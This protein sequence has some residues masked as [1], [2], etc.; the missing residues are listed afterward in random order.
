MKNPGFETQESLGGMV[1]LS[2][3]VSPYGLKEKLRMVAWWT[4]NALLFRGS[5]H[6]AN[7]FRSTLLR[8]FGAKIGR[9]V[10]IGPT[11]RITHPWR[12]EIGDHSQVG[13]HVWLYSLDKIV[14]GKN[15]M[16]SQ[17]SF[18]CTG[19]HDYTRRDMRLVTG[20]IVI[21][22]EAWVCAD[23]FV[24]PKVTIG[25]GTVVGARSSVFS[26]MP[27]MMVCVGSPCKP[28]KPRVIHDEA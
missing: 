13:D 10:V 11:V 17:K 15:A 4:A 7:G 24:G 27:S 19:G 18:L 6:T 25:R 2:K 3:R 20:P 21:N 12:V 23:C 14:I 26:D 1:D 9:G 22:D 5:F 28:L 8:A 16:V